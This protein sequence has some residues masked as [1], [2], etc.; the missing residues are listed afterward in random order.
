MDER[1]DEQSLRQLCGEMY[2]DSVFHFLK[3]SNGLVDRARFLQI[4]LN[5]VEQEVFYLYSLFCPDGLMDE[6][7]CKTFL[8]NAKLLAK[9]DLPVGKAAEI[10]RSY[11]EEGSTTLSYPKVR[12]ELIPRVAEIKEMTLDSLLLRFSRCEEPVKEEVIEEGQKIIDS[13]NTLEEFSPEEELARIKVSCGPFLGCVY[14]AVPCRAFLA[15]LCFH[16]VQK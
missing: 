9:K 13:V 11:L 12:F 15:L 16:E 7:T 8:R 6:L 4:A 2:T 5:V 3:D 1:L 14:A 10:F